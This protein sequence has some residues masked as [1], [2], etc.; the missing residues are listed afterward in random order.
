MRRALAV[1]CLLLIATPLYAAEDVPALLRTIGSH[2]SAFKTLKTDFVQEKDLAM[3]KH[4]LTIKG[5]IY[6]QKPNKVAWHVDSPIRYGVLMTD[7]FIRQWDEESGKVQEVSLV[8]NPI[9]KNV[10]NQL[11]VWFTGDFAALT[12]D[13]DVRVL[14]HAPLALEFTPNSKNPA[15]S[16]IKRIIVTFRDDEKYLKG[17]RIEETGKDVTTINFINTVIDA[18]LNDGDFKVERGV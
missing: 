4:R 17:I 5:R 14:S 12:E 3:F 11:N 18:P 6:L 15:R 13:N 10:L 2:V 7:K 1:I 9:L 16:V 8:G